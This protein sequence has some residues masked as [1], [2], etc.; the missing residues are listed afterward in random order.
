MRGFGGS[1]VRAGFMADGQKEEVLARLRLSPR[2]NLLLLDQ[3][4][5]SES[6]F[7]IDGR[8]SHVVI[9]RRER[10]IIGVASLRP[11]I[12]LEAEMESEALEASI[13]L[14]SSLETGLLKSDAERVGPVWESL[15]SRGRRLLLDRYEACQVLDAPTA[16]QGLPAL[17]PAARMRRARSGDLE[18]LVFAA[19]SSL[20]EEDRPDPFEGDADAFRDWVRGRI[21][22][23]RLLEVDGQPV[24]VGYADV[25]RKEG[26]L[27]Q[28]VYTW[29]D[30]RRRGYARAGM[31]GLVGE[32]LEAGAEHVQLA[33][34]EGNLPGLALYRSLG[35]ET[36]ARLRTILFH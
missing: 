27:V 20:V 22:R 21:G 15:R 6:E 36:I 26:W 35:F 28:G 12:V 17:P 7:R 4:A 3:V 5:G 33:V 18:A 30:Y 31:A 29:P 10:Q 32:A 13:P 14:L 19:R 23:A 8:M 9:T 11:S 2:H 24:F 34:V 16:R 25:R 1:R